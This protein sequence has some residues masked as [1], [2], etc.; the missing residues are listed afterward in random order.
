MRLLKDGH[1]T[2]LGTRIAFDASSAEE[3]LRHLQQG[4]HIGKVVL[5][6]RDADGKLQIGSAPVRAADEIKVDGSASYLLAGGLGGIATVI[7]RHLVENGARR[8]VCLSRNPGSK[9]EDVDTIKELES[10]GC[11]V[12]LVKGDLISRDDI[13]NAVQQARNLKGVLHAPMLLADNNFR[14]MT[15]EQWNKASDPKVKGAWYLH[16]AIIDRGIDLDFFVLLSSMSGLNGQP[17][18]ANYAGANTFLDAFAQ[19]RNNMGLVASSIDI[20]AVA[21]MGYAARDEA[22]LQRLITNGYSGVTQPEMIE[23]FTAASS[24]PASKSDALNKQSEPFVHRNTVATG[25]GSTVSLSNSES[26]SWWKKDI[27]MAV[28]HNISEDTDDNAAGGNNSL[29]AFLAKAKNEADTL[30]QPETVSYISLEIGKQ[31]MNLLLRSEDELDVTLPLAQLGLDSLVSI[32]MRTW[33]RQTFS[34]DISVIQLLGLGTLEELGKYAVDQLLQA[35]AQ[36]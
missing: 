25:F 30:R 17:G 32:E 28:W 3:A 16:E 15:L 13:S 36:A 10:M 29:K 4:Q 7:A 21:D 24:Y 23:A 9:P 6:M 11:E 33:W 20:G 5:T 31:L 14:N 18:Q 27:R 12:I 1:I 19:Y 34:A 22:L 8:L 2:P 26:R 35:S